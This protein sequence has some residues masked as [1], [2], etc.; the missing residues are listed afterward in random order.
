MFIPSISGPSITSIGRS[1]SLRASSV[2]STTQ[3]A[4]PCTSACAS[5]SCTGP[6]R[7]VRSAPFRDESPFTESA[8]SS[9]RSVASGRRLRTTSSTRSSSC[10]G[11][12][13][14]SVSAPAFTIPMSIPA[15]TAWYRK[16]AW[17]ASRTGLFPR[18]EKDTLL[19]PPLIFANGNSALIR[20]TASMKSTA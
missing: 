12:S 2:S 9:S 19:T 14:Y 3:S 17:I 4:I 11:M 13:E 10:G 1:A 20:F 7:H 16:T 8:I 15:C 6:S 5:R 18:N